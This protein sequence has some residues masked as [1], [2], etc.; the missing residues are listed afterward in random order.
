MPDQLPPNQTEFMITVSFF[1]KEEENK[2]QKLGFM[3][4]S[5][6]NDDQIVDS[7][8]LWEP[9]ILWVTKPD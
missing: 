6:L 1:T 2:V 4:V 7:S 3:R 5:P 8:S 9:D